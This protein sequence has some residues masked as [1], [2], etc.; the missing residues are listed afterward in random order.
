MNILFVNSAKSWGGNELWSTNAANGLA[1]RGHQIHF[2]SRNHLFDEK[3]NSEIKIIRFRFSGDVD[4]S[5]AAALNSYI[6][7][8]KIDVVIATKRREYFIC[9]VAAKLAKTPI[10]FRLGIQRTISKYDLPQKFVLGK[11]PDA[12]I[13]NAAVVKS[14]LAEC[15]IIDDDKIKLIYNG[16]QFPETVNKMHIDNPSN[17]F[18]FASAGRLTAQKGYDVL[19]EA[20]KI[21]RAER[22]DFICVIAGEGNQADEYKQFT[23]DN[24]I[25]DSVQ[26]LGHINNSR[27][28]FAACD[29]ALI[30]SRSEGVPNALFE[31]WSVGK[32]VAASNSSGI[33][34][35][36]V[37]GKDGLM[38]SLIP[39]EL[40]AVMKKMIDNPEAAAEMGRNGKIKTETVFSM[41]KMI[42]SLE[43]FLKGLNK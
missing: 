26:F 10:V 35:V 11:L 36:V 2:A 6:N 23:I 42:N 24:K 17:K 9:A 29:S 32:P 20:V 15:S 33:P 13:V 40:A 14:G 12:V 21:L 7:R 25:E 5:T 22:N 27:E 37:N 19:L 16:Y 8:N 41:D 43:L 1:G 30:P 34:E 3:L 31:A 4:F 38:C 28:L 18:I 39:G